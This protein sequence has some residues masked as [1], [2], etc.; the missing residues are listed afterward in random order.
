VDISRL[1]TERGF[2]KN[3]RLL[4][5][6]ALL[7]IP[8]SCQSV[9]NSILSDEFATGSKNY[10]NM[11][12]WQELDNGP[13]V[14]VDDPLREEFKKRVQA[15]KDVKIVDY[16]IKNMDCR[17][18]EGLAEVKVEWDYYIPPSIKLKTL[19]DPQKWRHVEEK[20]RKGWLLMTLFPEF[21]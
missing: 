17:P 5:L 9:H 20:E 1:K 12:R 14:F 15:A 4:L 21:K 10:F 11:V 7:L 16:R 13:L 8:A 2:M 18:L 6:A 19:V 3:I